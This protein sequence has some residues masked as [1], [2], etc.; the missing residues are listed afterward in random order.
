MRS[1]RDAIDLNLL[2]QVNCVHVCSAPTHKASLSIASYIQ[3]SNFS[4]HLYTFRLRMKW[5]LSGNAICAG[6][7][8]EKRR[9]RSAHPRRSRINLF[10]SS[11][12]LSLAW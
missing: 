8:E 7:R 5:T 3:F 2:E 9:E 4:S 1:E 10:S 6:E 12:L 11:P